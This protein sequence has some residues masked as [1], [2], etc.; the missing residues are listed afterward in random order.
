MLPVLMY[1]GVHLGP[2]GPGFHDPVYSVRPHD[3]EQQ[4]DWLV[5]H[6][7]RSVLLRDL[8]ARPPANCV[9]ITFDDGDISNTRVALPALA[10]RGMRAEF[11]ITTD[12]IGRSGSLNEE[13]VRALAAAGMGVQSHGC[14]HRYLADLDEAELAFELRLSKQ[15]LQSITGTEV[16]A[17]ALPGGRGGE[18]ERDAAVRAGYWHFLNSAPGVN[19]NWKLCKYLQRLPITGDLT[20]DK[21]ADLVQWRGLAPRVLRARYEALAQAKQ[22][23]GNR[24]YERW[25][26]RVVLR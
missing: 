19:S 17:I 4:L 21:F 11:C 16:T 3:F 24:A 10:R 5:G 1:H 22:M 15:R 13:Q 26:E 14:T 20:L 23:L 18:R 7:Y 9:V 8:G 6:G 25:R 12:F 2:D